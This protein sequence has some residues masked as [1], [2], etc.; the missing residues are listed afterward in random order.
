MCPS[1]IMRT[2]LLPQTLD[3]CYGDLTSPLLHYTLLQEYRQKQGERFQELAADIERLMIKVL[4]GAPLELV[5]LV[6]TDAFIDAV[7]DPEVR[8]TVQVGCPKDIRAAAVLATGVCTT[9]D[10][11]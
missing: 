9:L 10:T 8:R 4:P 2:D 3:S 7:R 11:V 1:D 5:S 6:S